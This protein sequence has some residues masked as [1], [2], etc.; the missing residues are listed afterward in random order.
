MPL[1][2]SFSGVR[3]IFDDGL[4]ERV[5]I[6]YSAH[7]LSFIRKKYTGKGKNAG[8]ITIVIGTDTRPSR[9]ILKKAIIEALGCDIIDIGVS[10][11]PMVELCVR[12][13]KADGGIIITASHNEP[14]WNGFKFLDNDGGV[15]AASDMNSIILE[16]ERSKK[17]SD[18]S[19][20][21]KYLQHTSDPKAFTERKVIQKYEESNRAYIDFILGFLSKTD[22]DNIKK[23]KLK[24]FL[25]PNGGTGWI[26]R[27]ILRR[28]GVSVK[29]IN[30]EIGI[31][32]RKVEP[33]ESSLFYLSNHVRDGKLDFAAGFDCDA[34]R[35]E[36]MTEK[37]LVS[38]N[39][40]L[41]L[42]AD[43]ILKNAKN[44]VIVVNNATSLMVRDVA[45]KY[46]AKYYE[47][48]VGETNVVSL[49]YKLNAPI[50]GEGSSSGVIIPPNRCR[51]GPLTLVYLLKILAAQNLTLE[52]AIKQLPIYY[53]LRE[54]ISLKTKGMEKIVQKIKKYYSSKKY[55]VVVSRQ[56][57]VKIYPDDNSFI[58][59]RDSR[60]ESGVLRI[61]SDAKTQERAEFL[62]EEASRLLNSK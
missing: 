21:K 29:A 30:M 38:G 6:R 25:D 7:F 61:I 53:N 10:C 41:A 35:V 20:S 59:F 9:D 45:K 2:S 15:L 40:L 42:I 34:D 37:G 32:N 28:L 4:S 46:G 56:G 17:L 11:T 22:I 48:E 3:G 49:M 55:K 43:S 1:I 5:A 50:G 54:K 52:R 36:I 24:I 44:K 27:P 39:H 58:W 47:A 13:F 33:N 31:F 23:A 14:E 16:Y 62:M 60:T 26:A 12:H 57:S 18:L 51:D 8:K 19:F